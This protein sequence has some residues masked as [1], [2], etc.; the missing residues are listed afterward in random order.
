MKHFQTHI[1]ETFISYFYVF[2]PFQ[3][4][5]QL[6]QDHLVDL[7]YDMGEKVSVEMYNGYFMRVSYRIHVKIY[8]KMKM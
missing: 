8:I 6:F 2:Y 3:N 5:D 4:F 1:F 7:I